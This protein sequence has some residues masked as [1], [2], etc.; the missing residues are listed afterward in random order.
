MIAFCGLS[1]T[2]CPVFIATQSD[3]DNERI[4]VAELWSKKFFKTQIKPEEINCDGCKTESGRLFSH[5]KVCEIRKCG[6]EKNIDNCAYCN[7]YPCRKLS[8]VFDANPG[9]KSKLEEIRKTK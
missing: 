1:C 8:I 4:R 7:E 3:D 5:C 6:Q 2:D 9:A